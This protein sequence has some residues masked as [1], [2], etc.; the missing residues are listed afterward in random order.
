MVSRVP[1]RIAERSTGEA[2]SVVGAVVLLL[3]NGFGPSGDAISCN[4]DSSVISALNGANWSFLV[5]IC[6]IPFYRSA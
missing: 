6:L 5:A 3:L 2:Y 4:D 1:L